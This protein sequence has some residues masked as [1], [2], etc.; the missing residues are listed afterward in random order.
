MQVA[1][2]T[3]NASKLESQNAASSIINAFVQ[4]KSGESMNVMSWH[5]LG[6]SMMVSELMP[7][8]DGP[9]TLSFS[10]SRPDGDALFITTPEFVHSQCATVI[11][12]D[13]KGRKVG[14]LDGTQL[15]CQIHNELQVK[16]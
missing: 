2:F 10:L 6:P 3:P 15:G 5:L 8:G 16:A 4:A 1:I 11:I 9:Y 7:L 14:Y 13:D 12:K